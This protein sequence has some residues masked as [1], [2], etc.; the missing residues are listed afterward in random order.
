[1]DATQRMVCRDDIFNPLTSMGLQMACILV[2]S[3]FFHLVLRALG[4]PGPIAQILVSVIS[5]FLFLFL[6][7]R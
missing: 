4:Q 2:I 6:H 5:F 7:V 1:M 3:H